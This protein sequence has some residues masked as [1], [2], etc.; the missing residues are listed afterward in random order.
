[1]IYDVSIQ[2]AIG[3]WDNLFSDEEL[4]KIIKLGKSIKSEKGVL[5]VSG[6]SR[7]EI[8]KRSSDISWI[9][10]QQHTE[11]IFRRYDG[12]VN[13]LNTLLFHVDVQPLRYLQ[14]TK[15]YEPGDHYEWHWDMQIAPPPNIPEVVQQRKIS[16][17]T[18]LNDPEEYEGGVLQV[19][20]C[21]VIRDVPRE[22]GGTVA[23]L[24]FVNHRVTPVTKGTRYSLVGWCEGP[25]WR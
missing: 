13:R 3:N 2:D 9:Q 15:Y 24:S 11:W 20:P 1:M 4:T 18:Q 21:G 5:G 8:D 12:A 7:E 14:F 25:D 17:V 6:A 23:F 19:A 16:V 10:R 22:R